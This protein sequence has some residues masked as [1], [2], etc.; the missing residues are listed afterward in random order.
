MFQHLGYIAGYARRRGA[1][2]PE[3][4]AAEVMAIAWRRLPDIPAE[5][6]RPWLIGTARN[7]LLAQ[8]RREPAEHRE[9]D[10]IDVEAPEQQ[11]SPELDLDA[12]LAVALRS[13]PEQDRE[14]LLL[15][16]WQDLTPAQ[17][18]RSLGIS[19]AAFRMRLLRAR[20]RLSAQLTDRPRAASL[21]PSRPNWRHS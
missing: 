10:G 20:R 2:D 7:V 21:T 13:L 8:R 12:D 17:A 14:A 3:S 1:R 6:A 5:D 19:A 11:L 9:L 4:I 16:A 15:V 18:A